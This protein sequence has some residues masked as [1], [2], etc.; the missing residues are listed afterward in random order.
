M[1]LLLDYRIAAP[2]RLDARFTIAGFTALLGPSG[3]GKTTLLRALAGLVPAR[4]TPWEGLAPERRPVGYLP[5]GSALFPHL[6][7]LENAAYAL[8][9]GDRLSRARRLM[10]E[11]GIGHL[12]GR[13]AA[14][15]S[16]GEAQR[17]G[18]ARALARDPALL[19]LDE[20]S[21]ALDAATKETVFTA[22]IETIDAR[23]IPALAATHDP[24]LAL[25]ADRL[26]LLDE[27]GILQEG[28]PRDLARAPANEAAARLLG[29]Q[30]I[31]RDASGKCQAIRAEDVLLDD[32]PGSFE[33][34]VATVH[35]AGHVMRVRVD[36]P[37]PL[38]AILRDAP[39]LTPG[40]KIRLRLPAAKI[41][42]LP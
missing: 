20:P 21:A 30:N 17:V 41:V 1:S 19:L 2:V 36:A 32:G 28:A 29:F 27:G 13:A 8:R 12:A 15:L 38:V 23:R 39:A 37:I 40:A 3:A 5:Q 4:G 14:T 25:L 22:L 7:A 6:S 18:L 26:V 35:D 11:L 33:A 9:G 16:G 34:A 24:A 42:A 31:W 10:E